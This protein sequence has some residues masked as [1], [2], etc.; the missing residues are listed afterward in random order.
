MFA[1]ILFLTHYISV[2][3]THLDV[4]KRQVQGCRGDSQKSN[5]EQK[6]GSCGVVSKTLRGLQQ[7]QEIGGC[8]V[9]GRKDLLHNGGENAEQGIRMRVFEIAGPRQQI[10]ARAT[11]LKLKISV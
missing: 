7:Q 3:Y 2:S 8:R 5:D 4:Y 10:R 9:V 1:V 6:E 11:C